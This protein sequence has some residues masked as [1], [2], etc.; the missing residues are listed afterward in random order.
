MKKLYNS[1]EINK[2]NNEINKNNNEINKIKDNEINNEIN[3]ENNDKINNSGCLL[4]EIEIIKKLDDS[5]VP[6][7][8]NGLLKLY[9]YKYNSLKLI[10]YIYL[11]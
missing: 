4:D 8:I 9:V 10:Y 6:H 7:T 3:N 11:I 5:D 2:D 1:K